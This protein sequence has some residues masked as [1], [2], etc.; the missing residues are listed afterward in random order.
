MDLWIFVKC[1]RFRWLATCL[2]GKGLPHLKNGG[3][4]KSC[5]CYQTPP[6]CG[7][8][9]PNLRPLVVGCPLRLGSV[10][11]LGNRAAPRRPRRASPHRRP[12]RAAGLG[13]PDN[14]LARRTDLV[15][16]GHSA[17]AGGTAAH[18]GAQPR[19]RGWRP[20][21]GPVQPLVCS[22]RGVRG[23]PDQTP[24]RAASRGAELARLRPAPPSSQPT[25]LY[26]HGRGFLFSC[27]RRAR[28]PPEVSDSLTSSSSSR[29]FQPR[30]LRT[31][32]GVLFLITLLSKP[33]I[34]GSST[35]PGRSP[36]GVFFSN[37]SVFHK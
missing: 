22:L 28:L 35:G 4:E 34:L 5:V 29:L 31:R 1:T 37:I 10:P 18:R 3:E 6:A 20:V 15:R 12:S 7:L 25:P 17:S 24:G 23:A 36:S 19:A 21:A 2:G 11:L 30:R 16:A 9:R 14:P 26:T 33:S 13:K 32:R 27:T 8:L